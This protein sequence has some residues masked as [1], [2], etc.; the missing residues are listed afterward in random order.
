MFL[1]ISTIALALTDIYAPYSSVK[2]DPHIWTV[3]ESAFF[4]AFK[5]F[6]WG[7]FIVWLIFACQYNYAGEIC[8]PYFSLSKNVNN[9]NTSLSCRTGIKRLKM[10]FVFAL[11]YANRGE[12]WENSRGDQCSYSFI[13]IKQTNIK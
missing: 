6:I 2:E 8:N 3:A 1:W 10:F 11:A 7:L 5:W 4:W 13:N 12:I 9:F